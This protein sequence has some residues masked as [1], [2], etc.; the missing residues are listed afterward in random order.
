L[1]LEAPLKQY[2]QAQ[3]KMDCYLHLTRL[4]LDFRHLVALQG[5]TT[6]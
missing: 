3:C 6:V 4:E 5:I 2:V 1:S